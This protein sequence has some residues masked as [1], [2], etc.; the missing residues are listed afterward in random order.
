VTD[1][2]T[3]PRHRAT[4]IR[5]LCCAA[6]LLLAAPLFV[7]CASHH[8][9][10]VDRVE[11]LVG[12]YQHRQALDY[13]ERYLGRHPDSL[14][15]WTYKVAIRLELD[16]RAAAAAEYWRMTEVLGQPHPEILVEVV[17]G[18][19]GDW[20]VADYAPLSRCAT[21]A[22]AD[23][24]F[25]ASVL[26]G[27]TASESSPVFLAPR[28]E[29]V[30]GVMDA[31]PGRYGAAA[32]PIVQA[33]LDEAAPEVRL[34][35]ARA[36]LRLANHEPAA[37]QPMAHG[38]LHDP[39]ARVR[40]GTLEAV[41]SPGAGI[42]LATLPGPMPGEA[43]PAVLVA[44]LAVSTRLEPGA[45]AE[46]R[47]SIR[48]RS[49]LV[50][51]LA[52]PQPPDPAS[53]DVEEGE[54]TPTAPPGDAPLLTLADRVG[55]GDCNTACWATAGFPERRALLTLTAPVLPL[56]AEVVG[57]AAV[58][59]DVFVR[60]ELARYLVHGAGDP[61]LLALLDDAEQGVRM[62]AARALAGSADPSALDVLRVHA[63]GGGMEEKLSLLHAMLSLQ[64]N[65]YLP[66]AEELM[67]DDAAL[68]REAAVG[69]LASSCADGTAE[70]MRAALTDPDPHVVV[71]A[72]AALYLTIGGQPPTPQEA[73]AEAEA[74][75]AGEAAVDVEAVGGAG[76]VAGEE[77][78]PA[79]S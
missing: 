17:L 23:P 77:E 45:G 27:Y 59:P 75:G 37:G 2:D 5:L 51:A 65:P 6:G 16:Q 44:W 15:G 49:P 14:D 61:V 35:A 74:A 60:T 34:A 8:Q 28:R 38:A 26:D 41:L 63:D 53:L 24:T 12:S 11:W 1:D 69:P 30:I 54:P 79:G 46:L 71:R 67:A 78:E 20:T 21:D 10:M 43:D 64:P 55:R 57:A 72:A 66:L 76:E 70:R 9:R 52:G 25:F 13:L 68:V 40:R 48:G 31:M 50:D 3:C 73:G 7:G 4:P 58:D 36:A 33:G 19:G 32:A 56:P 18:G 62:A 42:D 39:T 29:T 47:A 22:V